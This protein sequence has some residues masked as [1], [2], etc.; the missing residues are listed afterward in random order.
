MKN[1]RLK[2]T[3][4]DRAERLEDMVDRMSNTIAELRGLL[5]ENNEVL[6]STF[7]ITERNGASTNWDAFRKVVKTINERTHEYLYKNSNG[8]KQK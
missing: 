2:I 1:I 7:A 5:Y 6:R 4:A 8:K 3:D